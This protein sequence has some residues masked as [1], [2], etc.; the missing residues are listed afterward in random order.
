M[1][2]NVFGGTLNPAQHQRIILTL[3]LTHDLQYPASYD[4]DLLS[5]H[6]QM[7]KVNGQSVSKIEW[8]QTDRWTDTTALPPSLTRLVK[9][10]QKQQLRLSCVNLKEQS[11]LFMQLAHFQTRQWYIADSI[12]NSFCEGILTIS[13][14]GSLVPSV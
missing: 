3:T 9:M 10:Q 5:T 14:M 2:Y 11:S 6:M 12:P 13:N 1:T 4:H 7:F 8:K